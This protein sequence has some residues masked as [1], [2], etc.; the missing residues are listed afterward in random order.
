MPCSS[1]NDTC[2]RGK[3]TKT[4]I[5][6]KGYMTKRS[7]VETSTPRTP[8]IRPRT[9][10]GRRECPRDPQGGLEPPGI[11]REPPGSPGHPPGTAQGPSKT[12]RD[13]P[14]TSQGPQCRRFHRTC[15]QPT[16]NS[17]IMQV[18]RFW[19]HGMRGAMKAGLAGER[20]AH[21]KEFL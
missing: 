10:Q 4:Y 8:P 20:K 5:T 21:A 11:P 19:P 12:P 7:A 17:S 13:H 3:T 16:C 9:P 6:P 15:F 1:A 18:A 14:G 2:S